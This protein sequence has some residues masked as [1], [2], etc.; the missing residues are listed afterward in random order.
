MPG[1]V[2]VPFGQTTSIPLTI[3]T[4]APA[5]GV[6]VTLISS[7]PAAVGVLTPTVT[8]AEFSV[9]APLNTCRTEP[10]FSTASPFLDV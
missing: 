5:G 3:S 10:S 1:T 4:P 7:N 8:I 2:N 9:L 6:D